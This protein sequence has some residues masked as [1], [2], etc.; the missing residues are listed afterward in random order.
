MHSISSY[1]LSHFHLVSYLILWPIIG[2]FVLRAILHSPVLCHRTVIP[3]CMHFSGSPCQMVFSGLVH[4]SYRQE[5]AGGMGEGESR[6]FLPTPPILSWVVSPIVTFLLLSMPPNISLSFCS[7]HFCQLT[8]TVILW[9]YQITS[10]FWGLLT[11]LLPG[12][13]LALKVRVASC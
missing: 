2:L 9:P 8:L 5:L 13:P 1:L 11:P 3:Y 10:G 7:S 12:V 6:V 4:G